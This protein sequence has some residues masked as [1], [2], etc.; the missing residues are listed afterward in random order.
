MF[1]THPPICVDLWT[2]PHFAAG[3]LLSSVENCTLFYNNKLV[4]NEAYRQ[5]KSKDDAF[6]TVTSAEKYR[7]TQ[8][9]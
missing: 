4:S 6:I 3:K 8:A 9:S 2:C 7:N 5:G 1:V